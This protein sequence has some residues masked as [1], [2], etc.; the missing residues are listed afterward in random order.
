MIFD[1]TPCTSSVVVVVAFKLHSA[2]HGLEA[3]YNS[4]AVVGFTTLSS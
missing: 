1:E 4:A 3:A 2:F